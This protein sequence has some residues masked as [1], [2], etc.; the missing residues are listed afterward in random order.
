[1]TASGAEVES[2]EDRS[3]AARPAAD[4]SAV[5]RADRSVRPAAL[6]VLFDGHCGFC[7]RCVNA[8]E[9]RD[10]HG[11][12]TFLAHQVPGVRERWGVTRAQAEYQLWA[13]GPGGER[14]GGAQAVAAILDTLIGSRAGFG[15]R[16]GLG[17]AARLESR[18][19]HGSGGPLGP[20]PDDRVDRAGRRGPLERVARTPGVEQLLDRAYQWVARNRARFPGTTPWCEAHTGNCR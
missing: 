9:A 20:G 16:T 15:S 19:R 8:V 14:A 18:A 6:T 3:A 4:R 11:R 13:I 17:P 5:D 7:T 2:S 10:T 1:M 12:I